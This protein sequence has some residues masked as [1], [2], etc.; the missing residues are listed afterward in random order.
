MNTFTTNEIQMIPKTIEQDRIEEFFQ[1]LLIGVLLTSSQLEGQKEYLSH[2][3]RKC[4][5]TL[6]S[7]DFLILDHNQMG[8]STITIARYTLDY[9]HTSDPNQ[10]RVCIEGSVAIETDEY[11]NRHICISSKSDPFRL[12]F[13]I[14]QSELSLI[15]GKN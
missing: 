9:V 11:S 1:I 5:V 12:N 6:N 8:N 4:G 3:L 14:S 7:S 10:K 2:I 13:D 15:S